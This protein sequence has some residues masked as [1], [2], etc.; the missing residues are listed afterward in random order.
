MA[1]YRTFRTLLLGTA[2]GWKDGIYAKP[3]YNGLHPEGSIRIEEW[4]RNWH[5]FIDHLA[6]G[7][8]AESFF[9]TLQ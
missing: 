3:G 1:I 8:T 5:R 4:K 2:L 9:D 7:K 6:D